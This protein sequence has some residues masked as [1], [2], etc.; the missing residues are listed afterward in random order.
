MTSR[1]EQIFFFFFF[2]DLAYCPTGL[3]WPAPTHTPFNSVLF[4]NLPDHFVKTEKKEVW[5][6]VGGEV[7]KI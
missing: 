7:G 4:F 1:S 3:S 2:E 6:W 5:S